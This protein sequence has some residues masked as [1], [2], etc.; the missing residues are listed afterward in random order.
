MIFT[1]EKIVLMIAI[2]IVVCA[3]ATTLS[4]YKAPSKVAPPAESESARRYDPDQ[5]L[6]PQLGA[7]KIWSKAGRNPYLLRESYA[8]Q[9]PVPLPLPPALEFEEFLPGIRINRQFDPKDA[10]QYTPPDIDPEPK[11]DEPKTSSNG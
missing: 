3:S 11:V 6:V 8:E 2:V 7:E 10:F 4:N 9:A 1:K 5:D